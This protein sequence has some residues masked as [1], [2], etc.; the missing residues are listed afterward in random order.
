MVICCGFM[1]RFGILY[2]ETSGNPG[3]D[4]MIFKKIFSPKKSA[5]KIG[6][7]NSKQS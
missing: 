4:V 6:V 2:K 1:A 5:K 7:F 3:T